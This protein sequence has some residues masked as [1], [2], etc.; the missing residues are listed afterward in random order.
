MTSS[1]SELHL[2]FRYRDL[3]ANTLDE[4]RAL[5]NELEYC[6]WGWWKRPTE[7]GRLAVW[8]QLAATIEADGSATVGLF[9]SGNT[10]PT[11]HTAVVTAVIGPKISKLGEA[12]SPR[13]EDPAGIPAYYRSKSQ[14]SRAWMKISEISTNPID[15]FG[16]YSYAAA[17]PLPS[18]SASQLAGLSDKIVMDPAELRA[19]DTTIWEVRPAKETDRSER[20]ILAAP[21]PAPPLS[22]RA[23]ECKGEWILHLTDLHYAT[24]TRR[25][26]HRWRLENEPGDSGKQSLADAVSTA[27]SKAERS[28]GAVVV[29]GDLTFVGAEDEFKAAEAGLRKLTDG[30]LGL[31]LDHVVIVPGNHDIQWSSELE[32]H[33]SAEVNLAP[34][35]AKAEYRAFFERLYR[36]P[37]ATSLAVARR[38]L[39]P[40]GNLVDIAAVN[41]SSLE[42]GQSFLAGMGRVQEAAFDEASS[43]LG[44]SKNGTSLR[45]LALHHHL[46]NTEDLERVEE[47]SSGFGIAIDA[48]RTV[49]RAAQHG[50]HLALHGHKHRSFVWRVGAYDSVEDAS[51]RWELGHLNIVGGGSA[52]STSTDGPNNFFNL[53]RTSPEGVELEI[54][55]SKNEG[56]FDRISTWFAPFEHGIGGQ[57]SLGPWTHTIGGGAT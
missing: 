34:E 36:Q 31:T 38:L 55:R 40:G 45:V 39:M 16:H 42:Q 51:E 9:D 18:H 20:L 32:Y 12:L 4:H 22:G 10:A 46:V 5:I 23:I 3:T 2:L 6:W 48:T 13:P 27:L 35:E 11:V 44:W 21:T 7:D 26:Q 52:G 30:L 54:Y 53:F 28:V 25:S 15:F 33:D 56:A 17:P 43:A 1:G 50:V 49:R 19:M 29:T 8:G 24:G 14:H 47:Y 57:N 41:S 37:A